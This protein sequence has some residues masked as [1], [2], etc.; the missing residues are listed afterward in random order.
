VQDRIERNIVTGVD[1]HQKKMEKKRKKKKKK[2]KE[3]GRI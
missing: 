2:K 1:R 3:I